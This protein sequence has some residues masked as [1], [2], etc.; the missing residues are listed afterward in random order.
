MSMEITHLID[1]AKLQRNTA[2]KVEAEQARFIQ[3]NVK[4]SKMLSE[5]EK[6]DLY[7]SVAVSSNSA[8]LA[9]EKTEIS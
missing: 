1:F 8:S 4:D 2:T 5:A 6:A 7:R 3:I 9:L